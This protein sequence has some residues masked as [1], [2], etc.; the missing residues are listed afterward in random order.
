MNTTS[1]IYTPPS[2]CAHKPRGKYH[3]GV[4]DTV[5]ATSQADPTKSASNQITIYNPSNVTL[6]PNGNSVQAVTSQ[7]FT[8]TATLSPTVPGQNPN[9][10]WQLSGTGCNG[11]PCGS[12]STPGPSATTMYTPPAGLPTAAAI[13]DQLTA[14]SVAEPSQSGVSAITVTPLPVGLTIS[15]TPAVTVIA[16]QSSPIQFT[17]MVT[18]PSNLAVTWTL[19]G[20]GCSGEP[21]GTL[22]SVGSIRL[23]LLP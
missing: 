17:A 19:S 3:S 14:T 6:K 2:C 12:L 22:S 8:V 15:P 23:L 5:T 20:T 16:T 21:C 10:T 18:G 13:T 7:A 1:G 9:F 11:G 4:V